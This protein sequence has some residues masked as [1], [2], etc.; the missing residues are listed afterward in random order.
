MNE[1]KFKVGEVVMYQNGDRNELGIVKKVESLGSH[2]ENRIAWGYRVWYHTGD[3]TAMTHESLLKPISNAYAY[4]VLRRGVN[5]EM[6]L[7]PCKQ[8]AHKLMHALDSLVRENFGSDNNLWISEE[9]SEL[10][11]EMPGM[12]NGIYEETL[13]LYTKILKG[14]V[15]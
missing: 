12:I 6:E 1:P 7:D 11:D 14:E 15:K 3:T 8:M 9:E 2:E 4:T 13:E 5:P 10:V